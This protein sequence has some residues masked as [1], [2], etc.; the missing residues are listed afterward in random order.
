MFKRILVGADGSESA[1]R[2]VGRAIEIGHRFDAE[3]AVLTV[4]EEGGDVE[5]VVERLEAAVG[6]SV[7]LENGD[8]AEVLVRVTDAETIDLLVLGNRGMRGVSRFLGSVPNKVSHHLESSL[9]LVD[10]TADRTFRPYETVVVGTDGSASATRAVV[11]AGTVAE[12]Y[13]AQLRVVHCYQAEAGSRHDLDAPTLLQAGYAGVRGGAGAR[14]AWEPLDVARRALPGIDAVYEHRRGSPAEVL[15]E[16]VAQQP[17]PLLVAGSRG[18]TGASRFL[19]SVPNT[20]THGAP[21]DVLIVH[22]AP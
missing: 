6:G 16:L 15:A 2:A 5:R 22:T 3:V 10:T 21:C 12:R 11:A 14:Q 7:R 19:G 9:L 18:M 1:L 8:P 4:Q 13:S 20:I 17:S